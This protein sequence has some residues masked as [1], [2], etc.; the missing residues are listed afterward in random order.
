MRPACAKRFSA[1]AGTPLA[2]CFS[3]L[4]MV[5]LRN[6]SA[7]SLHRPNFRFFTYLIT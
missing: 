6:V 1:K 7:S 2:N 4:L 3:I 5:R